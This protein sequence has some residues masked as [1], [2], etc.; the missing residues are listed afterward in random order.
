MDEQSTTITI[1]RDPEREARQRTLLVNLLRVITLV[2]LSVVVAL[3]IFD[4][5]TQSELGLTTI[6][7]WWIVVAFGL[8]VFG[9]VLAIDVLTPRRK[10]SSLS[11]IIFGVF[12]GV[13]LTVAAGVILDYLQVA[14]FGDSASDYDQIFATVKLSIGVGLCYL[15]ASTIL[16]TQDDFRLVIPYVEFAKQIRGPKPLILDTS[17][18][19]DGRIISIAEV[20]LIQVPLVAPHFVIDE[21]HT[22]SDSGDKLKRNRGRRGLDVLNKLQKNPR[23]DITIET[24]PVPG[25][26]VDAKL[27]ELA[28]SMPGVILS[29][30]SGLNR[31]ANVQDV[32]CLNLHDLAN[33]MKPNVI[34]GEPLSLHLIKPGEHAGQG[35]G[36]LD[37][38]TMVVAENGGEFV[39]RTV[40]LHVT[41]TMQTS[42]GR[43]IFG[44]IPGGPDDHHDDE[45]AEKGG[46][47]DAGRE[48]GRGEG[49]SSGGGRASGRER[50][51]GARGRPGERAAERD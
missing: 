18:L 8:L 9:L 10:L 41:S 43:L 40:E 48:R 15:G 24:K 32:A 12:A 20:G 2:L 34:P 50:S 19:I 33:A 31:V 28:R 4:E 42:A 22:L 21:L 26:D 1:A 37:D 16:Q 29:T 17:T 47:G 27:I 25:K 45:G 46:G 51:G 14:F 49:R 7:W 11:A 6:D 36:Y 38:G 39:G 35:V 3:G 23:V 30:D 44:R 13:I 5:D